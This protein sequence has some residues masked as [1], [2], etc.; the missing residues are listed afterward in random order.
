[1]STASQHL[2]RLIFRERQTVE[3]L[4]LT[5]RE[6]EVLAHMRANGRKTTCPELA[7]KF[8]TSIQA[9]NVI[10]SRL[11]TKGYVV[12]HDVGDP[13]GGTLYSYV[14]EATL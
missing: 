1:M 5:K 4:R 2:R 3:D 14:L 11:V 7:E 9:A 13:T 10:A 6:Y 8:K 12:R